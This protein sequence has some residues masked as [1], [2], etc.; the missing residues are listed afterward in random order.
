MYIH[1][2]YL[3]LWLNVTSI[4]LISNL[5]TQKCQGDKHVHRQSKRSEWI[6]EENKNH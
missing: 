5:N 3:M 4:K 2:I 1:E 6:T